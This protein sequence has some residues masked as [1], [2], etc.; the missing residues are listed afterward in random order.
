VEDFAMH[1][2]ALLNDIWDDNTGKYNHLSWIKRNDAV[3]GGKYILCITEN[4]QVYVYERHIAGG[5]WKHV[6]S[7]PRTYFVWS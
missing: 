2:E 7:D 4:K 3:T 6:G 5:P 1:S